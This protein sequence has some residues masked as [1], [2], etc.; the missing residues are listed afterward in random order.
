MSF[1]TDAA[2]Y[3]T[4]VEVV[5]DFDLAAIETWLTA[6]YVKSHIN[7]YV[8][9]RKADGTWTPELDHALFIGPR[10]VAGAFVKLRGTSSL[11][12]VTGSAT[13]DPR[14]GVINGTGTAITT[15]Q[16]TDAEANDMSMWVW[17]HGTFMGGTGRYL[18]IQNN[19]EIVG[20]SIGEPRARVNSGLIT[21]FGSVDTD[22]LFGCSRSVSTEYDFVAKSQSGTVVNSGVS[23]P[24]GQ[25]P[26]LFSRNISA[27]NAAP[28]GEVLSGYGVGFA[29]NQS[30]VQTRIAALKAALFTFT[31]LTNIQ[32]RRRRELSG[33]LL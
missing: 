22:G 13:Y 2:A 31:P 19:T 15:D 21:S 7:A 3:F 20:A 23:S 9:G 10:T 26:T 5:S 4:A 6:D 25:I 28:S 8:L 12:I 11:S 32:P 30:L 14:Q 24:A 16:A 33:G 29:M 18:A 27:G 1:D 17:V